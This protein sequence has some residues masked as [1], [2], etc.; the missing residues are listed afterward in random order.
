MRSFKIFSFDDRKIIDITFY[1][2]IGVK[3]YIENEINF[4]NPNDY[5]IYE[6]QNNKIQYYCNAKHIFNTPN[7]NLTE[8]ILTFI[9]T[10]NLD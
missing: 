4:F 10:D 1:S 3:K 8:S 7:L 5:G 2:L 6:Y 9:N